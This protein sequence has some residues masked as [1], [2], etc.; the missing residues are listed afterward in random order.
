[1]ILDN[2]RQCWPILENTEQY[3]GQFW[4]ILDIGHIGYYN[5]ITKYSQTIST[6]C[7]SKFYWVAINT[8]MCDMYKYSVI[9]VNMIFNNT[10]QYWNISD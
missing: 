6:N 4:A 7:N 5:S 9:L 8:S 3:I 10:L 1:M 2:I